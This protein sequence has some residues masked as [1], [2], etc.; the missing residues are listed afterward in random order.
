[1]KIGDKVRFLSEVGGGVIAGFQGKDIVLVEDEDGFQIPT[2]VNQVV[3][4]GGEDYSTP[5]NMPVKQSGMKEV[6]EEGRSVKSL[7]SVD[8]EDLIQDVEEDIADKEISFRM[9]PEERK[10]GNKL[11]AYLACVPEDIKAITTTRFD[12]YLVND[13]NYY[14]RFV[15]MVAEG[16]SWQVKA[17]GEVE[18]N[19]KCWIE[20]FGRENLNSMEHVAMQL[21]AYKRDISFVKK[22]ALDVELR[23]D[24]VKFYKLHTFREND[25]FEVP[26]LLYTLVEQD[27]PARPLVIDAKRMKEEMY[28][29]E[30]PNSTVQSLG[31]LENA[32]VRRYDDGRKQGMSVVNRRKGDEGV[33]VIDLHADA[34]LDTTVGMDAAAIRE[35]Q[36]SKFREVLAANAKHKGHRIV[37]IHG[38]GNGVLRQLIVHELQY[39]YKNYSYQDAS[40]QEYGYGATQVTIK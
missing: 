31:T 3:V 36:L 40:F 16:N 28:K 38:K 22:P 30:L 2:P 34:L 19:M 6:L 33:E 18:P 8:T 11:S 35:H 21:L 14:L 4:D 15:Y 5:K 37:F 7:L 27:I 25:F 39:R 26:A 13:S 32:Y 10:G 23:I 9:K 17:E 1:M 12:T 24:G 20:T 29:R